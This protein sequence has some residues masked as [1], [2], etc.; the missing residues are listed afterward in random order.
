[1][2]RTAFKNDLDNFLRV[3]CFCAIVT[4]IRE[5]AGHHGLI[6]TWAKSFR[7]NL[8]QLSKVNGGKFVILSRRKT[9]AGI[10]QALGVV[11]HQ[12]QKI[13]SISIAYL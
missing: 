4:K 13:C 9:K 11:F 2:R 6:K 10:R 5:K 1:V 7:P 8:F 3:A 12:Q